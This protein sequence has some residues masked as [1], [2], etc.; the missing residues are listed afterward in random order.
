MASGKYCRRKEN[1]SSFQYPPNPTGAPQ[2][3]N[4]QRLI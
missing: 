2:D 3:S 4:Y 1:Y